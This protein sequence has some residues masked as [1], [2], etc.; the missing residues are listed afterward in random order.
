MKFKNYVI[1]M[2]F[3]ISIHTLFSQNFNGSPSMVISFNFGTITKKINTTPKAIIEEALMKESSSI[4]IKDYLSFNKIM[5]SIDFYSDISVVFHT[6]DMENF[7]IM[8]PYKNLNSLKNGLYNLID[9]Q[10]IETYYSD[11]IEYVY[12]GE[13]GVIASFYN[14][15]LC[16]SFSSSGNYAAMAYNKKLLNG[17]LLRDRGYSELQNKT[18]DIKLW[19]DLSLFDLENNYDIDTEYLKDSSISC[20]LDIGQKNATCGFNVYMPH[21]NISSLDKRLDERMLKFIDDSIL[22]FTLSLDS[23]E[24]LNILNRYF[25]N[26][27]EEIEHELSFFETDFN[28]LGGD[29]VFSMLDKDNYIMAL[30]LNNYNQ[31][32]NLIKNNNEYSSITSLGNN[33][34]FIEAYD[35]NMYVDQDIVCVFSDTM[36]YYDISRIIN[37]QNNNFSRKNLGFFMNNNMTFYFNVQNIYRLMQDEYYEYD[38]IIKELKYISGS[39]NIKDNKIESNFRI[40]FKY[41]TEELL[42]KTLNSFAESL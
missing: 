15:I 23:N 6:I 1:I 24:A 2:L 13:D 34:Y 12:L 4:S 14:G 36:S 25:P 40:D 37:N 17:V 7:S 27:K 10:N 30:S 21:I 8:I 38:D 39:L 31:F 22:F 18:S 33:S 11:G 41:S 3:F 42:L 16:I 19:A 5:D 26:M 32:L 20:Y 9:T 29:L 28:M 35:F